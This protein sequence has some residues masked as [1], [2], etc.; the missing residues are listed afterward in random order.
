MASAY[1]E[2]LYTN[3]CFTHV[4]YIRFYFFLPIPYEILEMLVWNPNTDSAHSL[5]VFIT[6]IIKI[7]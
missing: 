5:P 1:I 4:V 3:K 6:E 2:R 7:K